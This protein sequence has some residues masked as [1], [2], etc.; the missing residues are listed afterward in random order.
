HRARSFAGASL[1]PSLDGHH[2]CNLHAR[3]RCSHQPMLRRADNDHLRRST[4]TRA[5][6]IDTPSQNSGTRAT[7]GQHGAG[8]E[9]KLARLRARMHDREWRRFGYTLIAGKAIGIALIL[10]IMVLGSSIFGTDVRAED[11]TL[12]GNDIVN[13]INTVWTLV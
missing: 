3:E 11:P 12:G 9:S 4:M 8:Y 5:T 6:A 2:H 7:R 1:H 10:G 13:P